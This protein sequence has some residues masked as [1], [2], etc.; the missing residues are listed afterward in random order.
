M[1]QFD[2]S[3]Y[4]SQ[5]FWLVVCFG[6][7]FLGLAKLVLPYYKR[8][9]EKRIDGLEEKIKTTV[10]LQKEIVK[11]KMV[12]IKQL[13]A[14]QEQSKEAMQNAESKILV[15]QKQLVQKLQTAHDD[16]LRKLNESIKNQ[17]IFLLENLDTFIDD[18]CADII[19]KHL[20]D[21]YQEAP[22][23]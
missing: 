15:E 18:C 4:S 11:L 7:T 23:G 16:K 5:I 13:D 17:R 1:P 12:R 19:E 3:T 9:L 10:Y 6:L 20:P 2:I 22:R 21:F 8:I 14:V